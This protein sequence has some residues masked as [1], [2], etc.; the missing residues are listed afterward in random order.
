MQVSLS[1]VFTLLLGVTENLVYAFIAVLIL[2]F[3]RKIKIPLPILLLISFSFGLVLIVDR[4]FYQSFYHHLSFSAVESGTHISQLWG[5]FYDEMRIID[6]INL[7]ILLLIQIPI[8]RRLLQPD[9]Y[10]FSGAKKSQKF[11]LLVLV[12]IVTTSYYFLFA[13]GNAHYNPHLRLS[14]ESLG[15]NLGQAT[16]ALSDDDSLTLAVI[17]QPM[18]GKTDFGKAAAEVEFSGSTSQKNIVLVVLESIGGLQFFPNGTIDKNITP[19]LSS[20]RDKTTLF[21]SIYTYYPATTRSHVPLQTGGLSFIYETTKQLR[22]PFHGDTLI[23]VLKQANYQSALVSA[24]SLDFGNLDQFYRQMAFDYYFDPEEESKKFREKNKV[25]SWGVFETAVMPFA[26][27]WIDSVSD[28]ETPFILE[29]FTVSSHHPYGYPGSKKERNK[30]G[31]YDRYAK[32]LKYADEVLKTLWDALE[33]RGLLKDT[34]I[35]IVGDHGQAFGRRHKKN[36]THRNFLYEENVRSFLLRIDAAQDVEKVFDRPGSIGDVMPTILADAA[37]IDI[38]DETIG[39][40]LFSQDYQPRMHFFHKHQIPPQWGVRDGK[41]K[42]ISRQI[43]TDHAELYDLSTDEAERN[44]LAGP[45]PGTCE[46][47]SKT[48]FPMVGKD[49]ET[50]Y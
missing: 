50:L 16:P 15:F 6:F 24:Q 46:G 30:L 21:N 25:H 34:L 3:L 18:Y 14:L 19:F 4:V 49:A 26:L 47:L 12:L 1:Q 13:V 7:V 45:I 39:Q 43:D 23:S 20:I 36:F 28:K 9:W 17:Q 41:W 22:Y 42:F 11:A 31:R 5:S 32:T 2:L 44:N 10:F 27:S 37:H 8:A 29:F 35:Y 38:S 33:K 40:D 48:G